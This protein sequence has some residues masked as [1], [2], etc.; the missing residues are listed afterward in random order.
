MTAPNAAAAPSAPGALTRRPF[1]AAA[2]RVAAAAFGAMWLVAAITK[3]AAVADA[4]EFAALATGGGP[5]AKAVFI[6]WTALE[7]GL[8]TA[9]LLGAF[10]GFLATAVTLGAATAALVRVRDQFGGDVRCRC[11]A[12][13]SGASVDEAIARNVW[14]LGAALVCAAL[15]WFTSRRPSP[16]PLAAADAG[17]ATPRP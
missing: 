14:L 15:A 6:A 9:M 10:R 12:A 1:L 7:A 11:F 2:L 13:V 16:T 5:P 4:Y 8:G 3:T 17:P